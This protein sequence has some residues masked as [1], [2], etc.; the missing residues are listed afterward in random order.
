M[1]NKY[2]ILKIKNINNQKTSTKKNRV[3]KNIIIIRRKNNINIKYLL[4]FSI[5][6]SIIIQ[7][8]TCKNIKGTNKRKL[9]LG[10]YEISLKI[11]GIGEQEII[12][13]GFNTM[14]NKIYC[15]GEEVDNLNVNGNK[16]N[17]EENESIITLKWDNQ[18]NNCQNMFLD[19]INIIEIDLSNFDPS[20][21]TTM[22]EMFSGCKQLRKIIIGN[23]F[24]SLIVTTV[25][26]MFYN[27]ALLESIDLSN[28]DTSNIISMNNM[29]YGCSSLISLD[30]S[31]FNTNSVT[32]MDRMF[33]GC[34]SLVSLKLTNFNTKL[35]DDMNY[36]FD[37]C[38]SL[39]SLDVSMFDTS[40]VTNMAYMFNNCKNLKNLY[41]NNFNTSLV[42][43]M[44]YM[45]ANCEKL[46]SLDLS[47]F[48]ISNVENIE[49]FFF[50]LYIFSF[51]RYR[52][53]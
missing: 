30:L 12:Y 29:F 26:Q 3:E 39:I 14:P 16:I 47:N 32:K 15:N 35:V 13:A 33:K 25:Y 40:S 38:E 22:R 5:F 37:G 18:L 31:N 1:K 23:N 48:N 28:F 20:S 46:V 7:P 10:I 11:K 52:L 21:V 4:L 44:R 19:L 53:F 27:C 34:T 43:N 2:R 50:K 45:F 17:I 49:K 6:I 42:K 41:L 9:E 24:N 51:I 36:M 8:I